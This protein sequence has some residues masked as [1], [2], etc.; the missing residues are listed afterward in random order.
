[1]SE[2][3]T[4]KVSWS[5]LFTFG[6]F[7]K[8]YVWLKNK[9]TA[10][11]WDAVNLGK[12]WRNVHCT[13]CEF[14]VGLSCF[15]TKWWGK[16]LRTAHWNCLQRVNKGPVILFPHSA[17]LHLFLT[18]LLPSLLSLLTWQVWA[19]FAQAAYK[20]MV[21][22]ATERL[23]FPLPSPQWNLWETHDTDKQEF[24]ENATS[25]LRPQIL[26]GTTIP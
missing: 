1:M 15:R 22:S 24:W 9:N 14:S 26:L 2:V 7:R 10:K 13:T 18:S 4:A 16:C 6:W 11:C 8:K 21:V 25:C 12:R 20:P 17:P 19:A 23:T 3:F 5:L